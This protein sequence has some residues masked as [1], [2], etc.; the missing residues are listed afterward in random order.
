MDVLKTMTESNWS[1]FNP[2]INLTDMY[3]SGVSYGTGVVLGSI[4]ALPE[5]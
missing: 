4:S 5:S 1:S 3:V 2:F